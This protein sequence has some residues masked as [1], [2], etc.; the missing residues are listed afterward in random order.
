M[1]WHVVK[2]GTIWSLAILTP[3]QYFRIRS[4]SKE[5]TKSVPSNRKS[6][7]SESGEVLAPSFTCTF[8][9]FKSWNEIH[10]WAE[11]RGQSSEPYVCLIFWI[12]WHYASN[13]SS[14]IHAILT[15][16]CSMG[17]PDVGGVTIYFHVASP[18]HNLSSSCNLT[19][20]VVTGHTWLSISLNKQAAQNTLHK[21]YSFHMTCHENTKWVVWWC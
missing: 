21:V 1:T 3:N 18:S 16:Q 4:H 14:N 15:K 12:I 13:K 2:E 7:R 19:D 5:P 20:S 17:L 8:Q 6:V 10:I 9:Q 11:S